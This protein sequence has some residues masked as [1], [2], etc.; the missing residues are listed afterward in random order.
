LPIFGSNV[1][2]AG[3]ECIPEQLVDKFAN[4]QLPGDFFFSVD[5]PTETQH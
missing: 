2:L 1:F 4:G 5:R 3:P